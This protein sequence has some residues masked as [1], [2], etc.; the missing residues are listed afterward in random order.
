MCSGLGLSLWWLAGS[1]GQC[2]I[3]EV[4][5]PAAPGPPPALWGPA[6]NALFSLRF[7]VLPCFEKMT[8]QGSQE[9]K[10]SSPL[11]CPNL[12]WSTPATVGDLMGARPGVWTPIGQD[13]L[14]HDHISN[15]SRMFIQLL[16]GKLNGF[17]FLESQARSYMPH[18]QLLKN[19]T[20]TLQDGY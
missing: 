17:S 3:S 2:L 9:Q 1:Q 15:V 13:C 16:E 7:P 6:H 5:L 20:I 14:G 8:S 11:Q 4:A 19:L 12:Q 10:G 18:T